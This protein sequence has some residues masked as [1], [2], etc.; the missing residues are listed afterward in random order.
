M[1]RVI[2][3]LQAESSYSTKQNYVRTMEISLLLKKALQLSY[4]DVIKRSN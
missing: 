2:K 3:V 1:Q 4:G